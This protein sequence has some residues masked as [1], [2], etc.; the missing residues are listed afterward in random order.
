MALLAAV[1]LPLGV[2]V[3]LIS[4]S[5]LKMS[6]ASARSAGDAGTRA[7]W[8]MAAEATRKHR[9]EADAFKVMGALSG[10]ELIHPLNVPV[11]VNSA[12]VNSA[13][14]DLLIA[15]RPVM[16]RPR[17]LAKASSSSNFS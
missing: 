2:S 1:T 8:E 11:R 10:A 17:L 6:R 7:F 14:T 13:A 16:V 9:E 12:L 4:I 3:L 5:C 15:G